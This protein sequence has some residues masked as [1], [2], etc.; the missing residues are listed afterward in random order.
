M[1]RIGFVLSVSSDT[2][3]GEDIPICKVDMGGKDIRAVPLFNASGV[4][5]RPRAGDYVSLMAHPGGS[6]YAAVA[7]ADPGN[8]SKAGPGEVRFVARDSN[9]ADIAEVYLKTDGSILIENGSGSIELAADG[10]VTI[11]DNFTVDI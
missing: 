6:G 3:G 5:A 11:N 4:D 2:E 7:F 9:G 1:G 10:R 8:T